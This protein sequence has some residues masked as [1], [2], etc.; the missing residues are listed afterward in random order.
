MAN[1]HLKKCSIL[2]WQGRYHDHEGGFPRVRLIH[3]TPDVLTPAISPN[4]GDCIISGSGG[5][6]SRSS[7]EKKRKRKVQKC[8]KSL[9]IREMQI[10]TPLRFHLEIEIEIPNQDG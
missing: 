8:S 4:A 1:K 6:R 5:L 9:V 3:C 10:R 2:T 7:L